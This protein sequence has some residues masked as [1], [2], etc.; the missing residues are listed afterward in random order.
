MS[1]LGVGAII[2]SVGKVAGDL[3]TT[4]NIT[5]K[6]STIALPKPLNYENYQIPVCFCSILCP[7]FGLSTNGNRALA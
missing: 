3:I 4:E 5:R 6:F 1:L 7:E 2:E